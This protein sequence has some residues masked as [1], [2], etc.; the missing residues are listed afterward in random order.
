MRP[1]RAVMHVLITLF[2]VCMS[3][4]SAQ[5]WELRVCASPHDE[6][7][8]NRTQEGYEN[9]I[10]ALIADE[11][12]A[13]L[14]FVWVPYNDLRPNVE[15]YLIP[16]LCDMFLGVA[17]GASGMLSTVAYTSSPYVFVY[18]ASSDINIE[19]IFDD[20]LS[21]LRIATY[22]NSAVERALV[23]QG[24][25]ENL[26]TYSPETKA[27]GFDYV[28]PIMRDVLEQKLDVAL[29]YGPDISA[30]IARYSEDL[31]VVPVLPTIAPPMFQMLR[32]P[33]IGVRTGDDALRDRLNQ[34]IVSRWEGIQAILESAHVPVSEVPKPRMPGLAPPT[35]RV[36][37]V[38]PTPTLTPTL[39]DP[40]SRAARQGALL[41]E[42]LVTLEHPDEEQPLEVLLASSPS[43]ESAERAAE[44]LIAV[45][46]VAALIGGVGEAQA[47]TLAK[48]AHDNTVPFLNIGSSSMRLR[49]TYQPTTFHVE[50]SSEMYLGA[51]LKWFE[52]Q[53]VKRWYV[54]YGESPRERD[55]YRQSRAL[56]EG[57]LALAGASA[58]ENGSFIY[59]DALD[60]IK[61]AAPDGVLLLLEP[62]DQESFLSQALSEGLDSLVVPFPFPETQ[63]RDFARRFAQASGQLAD[64]PRVTLWDA[65]LGS[66]AAQEVIQRYNSSLG[67]PMDPS[68][69]AAVAAVKAIASASFAT[70]SANTED[71]IC[72]LENGTFDLYKGVPLSFSGNDHQLT[73]PLYLTEIDS[74]VVWEPDLSTRLS[75][76]KVIVELP[77]HY[78]DDPK[79]ESERSKPPH[80]M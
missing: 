14:T 10:A 21:T 29:L 44:R 70:G 22:P 64:A 18:R 75:L 79:R 27:S 62:V 76:V 67:M 17:D 8:S 60:S 71:L 7:A 61:A 4:A 34:V 52:S 11:L 1:T 46:G 74:S 45:E 41:G 15:Q 63:T 6:P 39:E 80:C 36:G 78:N 9:K 19:T 2:I 69:W 48:V 23:E 42:D 73:Q 53:G 13:E 35:V 28:T 56:I 33:T 47:A 12:G 5:T 40:V 38:L 50:A 37:V 58:V 31:K 72:E 49:E 43:V 51:T 26:V 20:I 55:L 57:E 3:L 77:T 25:T 68:A 16:G 32:L 65:S 66:N 59:Y 54:I 24:L 30:F